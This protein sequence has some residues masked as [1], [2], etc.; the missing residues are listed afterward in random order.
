[1]RGL[2]AVDADVFGKALKL[3]LTCSHDLGSQVHAWQGES[4]GQLVPGGRCYFKTKGRQQSAVF[5]PLRAIV[6]LLNEWNSV[7]FTKKQKR[8]TRPYSADPK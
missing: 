1:M 7:H 5:V 4:N 2:V 8:N 6:K 3:L